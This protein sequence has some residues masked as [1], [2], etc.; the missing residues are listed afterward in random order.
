MFRDRPNFHAELRAL[1]I[2]EGR[3]VRFETKL[4]PI[5]DP[6]LQVDWL[7]NGKK[8]QSGE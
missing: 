6:E 3:P 7:L 5:N 2:I 8:I 1:E 4:T